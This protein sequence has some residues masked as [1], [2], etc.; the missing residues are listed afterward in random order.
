M[1]YNVLL[2]IASY[3]NNWELEKIKKPRARA[4]TIF[5]SG[6]QVYEG[7]GAGVCSLK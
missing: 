6:T 1:L 7:R 4:C 2:Y 5:K 3:K